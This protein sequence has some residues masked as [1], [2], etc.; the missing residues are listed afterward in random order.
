L[1]NL[2]SCLTPFCP[3]FWLFSSS[4]LTALGPAALTISLLVMV[5]LPF[6][7]W[8]AFCVAWWQRVPVLVLAA[9][10][11]ITASVSFIVM[12]WVSS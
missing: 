9:R 6:G 2:H 3:P 5:R 12:H 4:T 1:N 11:R 10:Y 7:A 8:F